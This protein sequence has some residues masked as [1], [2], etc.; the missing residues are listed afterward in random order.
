M[1]FAHTDNGMLQVKIRHRSPMLF[2]LKRGYG[3]LSMAEAYHAVRWAHKRGWTTTKVD[4][5]GT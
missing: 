3:I 5:G 4:Y 1:V 2:S